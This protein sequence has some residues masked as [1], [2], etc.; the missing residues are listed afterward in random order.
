MKIIAYPRALK[1]NTIGRKRHLNIARKVHDPLF[2]RTAR[3]QDQ[4]GRF[5]FRFDQQRWKVWDQ[6]FVRHI[7]HKHVDNGFHSNW[8]LVISNRSKPTFEIMS[9]YISFPP[10]SKRPVIATYIV[11]SLWDSLGLPMQ[12]YLTI[13][14]CIPL[15]MVVTR[16]TTR[17][18]LAYFRDTLLKKANI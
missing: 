7:Q 2:S 4:A 16:Q 13:S 17:I 6:L 3:Y 10:T 18:I 5:F 1:N 12:K 11:L 8:E 14:Q 15:K 9:I